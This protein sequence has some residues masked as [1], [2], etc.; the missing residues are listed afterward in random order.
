MD[1]GR[2][3]AGT[4]VRGGVATVFF[5]LSGVSGGVNGVAVIVCP[6]ASVFSPLAP[7]GEHGHVW[8]STPS[9]RV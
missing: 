4:G 9:S 6:G 8:V 1:N 2:G 3:E 7:V 5:T